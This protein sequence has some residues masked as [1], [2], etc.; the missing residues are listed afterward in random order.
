MKTPNYLSSWHLPSSTGKKRISFVLITDDWD[1]TEI[2]P[3]MNS[4]QN[5]TKKLWRYFNRLQYF[6]IWHLDIMPRKQ[7]V[8]YFLNVTFLCVTHEVKW[9]ETFL[10]Q[11]AKTSA[12]CT[13]PIQSLTSLRSSILLF[14]GPDGLHYYIFFSLP[15]A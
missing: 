12:T 2:L 3:S 9:M 13:E 10:S 4:K 14:S 11:T 1:T 7:K 6:K 5:K 8:V 15:T